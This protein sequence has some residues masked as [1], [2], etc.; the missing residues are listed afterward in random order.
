MKA[1]ILNQER[2]RPSAFSDWIRP[3]HNILSH[4]AIIFPLAIS[5]ILQRL[6]HIIDNRYINQLG[7]DALLVHNIQYNFIILGQAIGA[8][9]AMSCLIFWKRKEASGRQGSVLLRH[10]ALSVGASL[11]FAS[12][13]F[14]LSGKIINHF[15]IPAPYAALASTYLLF[16]LINMVLQAIYGSLDGMLIA[17]GQQKRS[18]LFAGVLVAGNWIFDA[19][20]IYLLYHPMAGPSVSA[21]SL[22]LLVVGGSTTLLMLIMTTVS[23]LSVKSSVDG[24]KPFAF[25]EILNVWWAEAGLGIVRSITPFIYAYQLGMITATKGFLVTY[26]LGLHVS[27]IFCLPFLA[28]AQLAIRDASHAFSERTDL[29]GRV[30]GWWGYLLYTALLPTVCLLAIGAL[31]AVP[32]LK[33]FYGY[34]VPIDHAAFLPIFY[35]ACIIGQ[36]GNTFF[37]PLR[38]RKKNALVTRNMLLVEFG[39]L[40]GGTQLLISMG[41]AQP[42]TICW[43]TI[44][45]TIG[46]FLLNL[47]TLKKVVRREEH[48]QLAVVPCPR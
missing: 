43:V 29:P 15:E 27:Y 41:A 32:L 11:F 6:Y 20:A 3:P 40:L 19:G 25:R 39:I 46:H 16:G 12:I 22:P 35:L 34:A 2:S 38:A 23:F 17:S 33:L 30:P 1:L 18:M 45:Y 47:L 36:L 10:L 26:Q 37:V 31:F 28:G 13:F 42:S 44:V 5:Q 14:P 8:A 24:W 7:S 48:D 21:I 4:F 9:T